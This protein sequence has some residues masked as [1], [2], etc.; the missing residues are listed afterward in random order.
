MCNVFKDI[1]TIIN[2][3]LQNDNVQQNNN[4]NTQQ[5][6][7]NMQQN[8]NNDDMQQNNDYADVEDMFVYEDPVH[9]QQSYLSIIELVKHNSSLN[10]ER[11]DACLKAVVQN[12]PSLTKLWLKNESKLCAQKLDHDAKYNIKYLDFQTHTQNN[13]IRKMELN[14]QNEQSKRDHAFKMAEMQVRLNEAQVAQ[15]EA[16]I[17]LLSIRQ[18]QSNQQTNILLQNGPNNTPYIWMNLAYISQCCINPAF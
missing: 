8:I 3:A 16:Q 14:N 13:K 10:D 1:Q 6:N 5:N 7:G 15:T 17:R 9:D 11:F 18:Q 4:D 12:N 2:N